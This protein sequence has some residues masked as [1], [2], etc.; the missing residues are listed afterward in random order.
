VKRLVRL[1][2]LTEE[3]LNQL[4]LDSVLWL[5]LRRNALIKCSK[6]RKQRY[7]MCGFKSEGTPGSRME[8]KAHPLVSLRGAY[9]GPLEPAFQSNLP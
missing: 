8:P 4:S 1:I 9:V 7:K 5:A 6:L 2:A 3:V